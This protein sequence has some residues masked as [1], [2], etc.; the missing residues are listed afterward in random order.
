MSQ[1]KLPE[2]ARRL[3]LEAI[4]SIEQLEILLRLATDPKRSWT[5][6]E[7]ARE[8]RTNPRSAQRWLTR[9]TKQNL[10]IETGAAFVF[11]PADPAR[12]IQ[13][14]SVSQAY[15]THRV[16][17]IE[18]IFNRPAARLQSFANAFKLRGDE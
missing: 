8:L 12:A 10:L 14:A 2:P 6:D 15:G 9:L 18:L 4:E 7:M 13:V 3:I 16:S 5:A 17:V 1:D 11:S